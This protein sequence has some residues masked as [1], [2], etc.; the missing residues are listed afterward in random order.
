MRRFRS[1]SWIERTF[2]GLTTL[3][4][5]ALTPH[6][7]RAAAPSPA[8]AALEAA[9]A[10]LAATLGRE[11]DFR[12]SEKKPA[13]EGAFE[14]WLKGVDRV[15]KETAGGPALADWQRFR[16]LKPAA[17]AADPL[18]PA[19]LREYAALRYGPDL[20][21]ATR[22]LVLC[23]TVGGPHAS[24][25]A[26]LE[27]RRATAL[28]DSLCLAHGLTCTP[29]ADGLSLTIAAGAGTP[30]LSLLGHLD[31]APA[32]PGWSFDAWRGAAG[33]SALSGRGATTK[34]AALAGFFA[35]RA[36]MDAD[37]AAAGLLMLRF[38]G[39]SARPMPAAGWVNL[40]DL[41]PAD[42]R[43]GVEIHLGTSFRQMEIEPM[44]CQW[45]LNDFKVESPG[46]WVPDRV[47]TLINPTGRNAAII[48]SQ[49]TNRVKQFNGENSRAKLALRREAS[50]LVVTAEGKMA[51]AGAPELGQN[52]VVDL[53]MFLQD[54][55]NTCPSPAIWIAT[56]LAENVAYEKTGR[57]LGIARKDTLGVGTSVCLKDLQA[58]G[59]TAYATLV[60]RHPGLMTTDELMKKVRERLDVFNGRYHAGI[61]AWVARDVP[62]T[63]AAAAAADAPIGAAEG[64]A[65]FTGPDT[66]QPHGVDEAV[67][68]E[69]VVGW[70]GGVAGRRPS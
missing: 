19:A 39:E 42:R 28:L 45:R 53:V 57:G 5:L 59:D 25:G 49:L 22:R 47:E 11:A 23:R 69:R 51:D 14:A 33:D 48:T 15:F 1:A 65:G 46:A 35:L 21:V 64:S 8:A 30:G 44:V 63:P 6:P 27:F 70:L 32:G 26:G 16:A 4:L 61:N 54:L 62:A 7:A 50:V 3:C 38:D 56:F 10:P 17:R 58:T 55:S 60:V 37:P 2:F 52:A 36:R 31:V 34:G 67:A 20:V 68:V 40:D 18:W 13:H 29:A 41:V 43:A 66:A 12:G 24:E 9:R